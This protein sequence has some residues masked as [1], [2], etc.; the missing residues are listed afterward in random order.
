MTLIS[1]KENDISQRP[2]LEVLQRLGYKYISPEEALEMRGGKLSNVLLEEVLRQHLRELNS[3]RIGSHSEAR[4][5][6]QNIE[7]GIVA[8]RTVPMEGGYLNG[9]EAVYNMLTLGRLNS[10]LVHASTP[11]AM[12]A[13]GSVSTCIF[14]NSSSSFSLARHEAVWLPPPAPLTVTFLPTTAEGLV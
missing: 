8:L 7:N 2:A 5:S 4:F 10:P 11:R 14:M 13:C 9:N 6:E 3:I 1:F 12:P